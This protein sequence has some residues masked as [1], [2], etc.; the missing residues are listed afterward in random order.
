MLNIVDPAK[1][2]IIFLGDYA[3]RG[4][5]GIEVIDAVNSLMRSYPKNVL[6][7]KG[8]HEDYT[9]LG[10]PTFYPCTLIDEAERKKGDWKNYFLSKFK[11]F[12]GNL[13]LAT[14]VPDETLFVHGGVS[15]KIKSLNDLKHP[16]KDIEK[17]VLWSDPFE[18]Y[19]EHPNRRGAGVEFGIDV[20][21][22]ICELLGV[23]RIVRSHEPAK[24][25][26]GPFYSHDSR[27]IT[28]SS[29]SVYGGDPLILSIDPANF[30]EIS[31]HFL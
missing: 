29:T 18:G 11:P 9:E 4:E 31:Y 27:V 15:G 2:G 1:D 7:L 24:A 8:N 10:E 14:I 16:T 28:T 19:G 22:K 23:K 5:F 20:T 3:D 21:M 17:D 6:S 13:Y 25:L 30:S 12:M 26:K